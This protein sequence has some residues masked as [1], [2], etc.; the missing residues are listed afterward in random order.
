V[1]R[2]YR[3]VFI[4]LILFSFTASFLL[5]FVFLSDLKNITYDYHLILS[6]LLDDNQQSNPV[7]VEIDNYSL[8]E[9]G[10]WPWPRD[11]HARLIDI[12][13]Q[14][15]AR[16]IGFDILFSEYRDTETDE[17]LA[18]TLSEQD[19]I[20]LAS[21]LETRMY[22]SPLASSL[23]IDEINK[24]ALEFA[25]Y[26]ATGFINLFPDRDGKIRRLILPENSPEPPFAQKIVQLA[27][28]NIF[29]ADTLLFKDREPYINFNHSLERISYTDVLKQN[30]AEEYFQNKIVIIGAHTDQI[31]DYWT[32]PL[33]MLKGYTAGVEIHSHIISSYLN[34]S[35][36][37]QLE[38]VFLIILMIILTPVTF[39]A[40]FKKRPL[41]GLIVLIFLTILITTASFI[42][43][44]RAH[45]YIYIT[46]LLFISLFNYT[47]ANVLSYLLTDRKRK[48]LEKMFARYL[49][50]EVARQLITNQKLNSFWSQKQ[51]VTI[52]FVDL[53]GFTSFAEQNSPQQT[54]QL[55][56]RYFELISSEVFALQGTLN[57]F[58]GDGAL[59]IF[60]APVEQKNHAQKA[61]NLA[62]RLQNKIKNQPDFPLDLAVGIN[63]G[64]VIA[65]SIGAQNR[66]EYTVIGD[67]VNTASLLEEQAGPGEIIVGEQ[68]YRAAENKFNFKLLK[69]LKIK[70]K[71]E[72]IKTYKLIKTI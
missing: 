34:S 64:S 71:Q 16:V 18:R 27:A 7:I 51:E 56:N 24:P 58:L 46:P 15:G 26:S 35:F 22:R 40:F 61:L 30:F 65:G 66:M 1:P 69:P 60:G 38:N 55:L 17:Q 12:L 72:L 42:L 23:L 36:I 9:E 13:K 68:T 70:G 39:F 8:T 45:I 52:L 5:A 29:P 10:S 54:V 28:E 53:V 6:H 33:V 43:F 14:N 62:L 37:R 63:T 47:G 67:P 49:S 57:K 4:I 44:Y 11:K 20:V 2:K 19:R 32:T 25:D 3:L 59:I 50:P 31:K 41:S 48:R 21:S